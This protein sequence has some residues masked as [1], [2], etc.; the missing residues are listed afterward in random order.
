[1]HL[2]L[3]TRSEVEHWINMREWSEN[4]RLMILIEQEMYQGAWNI[5]QWVDNRIPKDG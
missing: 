1:M 3:F 2:L 4:T 5:L